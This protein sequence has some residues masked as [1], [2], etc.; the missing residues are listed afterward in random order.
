MAMV[1]FGDVA[2]R[3]NTK[4]DR[5]KTDLVYYVGGDHIETGELR[6]TGRGV[7]KEADLGPM[8]YFG[9]KPGDILF[10]TRNPHLRKSAKVDFAGICSEKTLVIATKDERV[11]LQDYL[12]SVMQSDDFWNFME[13]NKSGSVNYFVNWST[14]ADYE[15]TLPPLPRQRELAELLWAA[16]DLK[17][18]YKKAIAAT[19]EMLKAKFR[20]MFGDSANNTKKWP[21][22]R[23]GESLMSIDSG[24][25]F[26]C[27]ATPRTGDY[28]GILKLSAVTY[29][30]YQPG[31]NKAVNSEEEFYPENEVQDG[32]LLFT[33]KNTEELVGVCAYVEQTPVRL[34]MPDTIFRLNTK[35]CYER[36]FLGMMLNHPDQRR[37]I[38][39]IA[40]GTNSSMVNISK[41]RLAN[42][43][44]ILP[45]LS[46]QREF[47]AIAEKAEAAKASL[48]QSIS[49]LDQVM[50]GLIN[51]V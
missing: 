40:G 6:V 11:L 46:L 13:E 12:A 41:E 18:A 7:I 23:L 2:E 33:R 36:R 19:D 4:E 20:E 51:N 32:D 35:D 45:P 10:V 29:G 34:M 31:E 27:Q 17:E 50:K 26:V 16:N 14:L 38:Q 30:H 49:T 22:P 39:S 9:F 21:M 43:E 5:F 42:L 48:K 47:V 37:R 3:V 8:F 44:M 24:K 28:P 25:S 15:F 1:R